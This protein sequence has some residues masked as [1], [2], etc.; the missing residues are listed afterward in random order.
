[1]TSA[2]RIARVFEGRE[3]D[4]IPVMHIGFSSQ[5]A[6]AMLGRE[7]FVGG[8]IQQYR[9]ACALYEGPQAHAAFLKR[10]LEDAVAIGRLLDHDMIRIGYWR[11]STMPS[12]RLD[13]HTFVYTVSTKDGEQRVIRRFVPETELFEPVGE[14]PADSLEDEVIALEE[15]ASREIDPQRR[16]ADV[17]AARALVE[18]TPIRVGAAGLTIPYTQEWLEAIVLE[19]ELVERLLDAQ[20]EKGLK[21]IAALHAVGVPCVFGGGDMASAQGPLYSPAAFRR[22]MLPRLQRLTSACEAL[23]MKYLFNSD[24]NLWPV[25]DM[26]FAEGGAHGYY[27][28]DADAGMDLL[29]LRK[30]YP[31]VVLFGNLSSNLLHTGDP[32]TVREKTLECIRVAKDYGRVVLGCSNQFVV[33]TP[34][35]NMDA[36]TETIVEHRVC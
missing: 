18:D 13:E 7:A 16:F 29:T 31:D 4:A 20:V 8:G 22:M 36:M 34:R 17:L 14:I 23:G 27:E 21:E 2:E 6:S 15:S 35:E 30:R 28:I 1:M 32:Q 25:A 24:G 3:T 11:L 19:P 5:V 26:I 10:S 33:G 9:E 12:D